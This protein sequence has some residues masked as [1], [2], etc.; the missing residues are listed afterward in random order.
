MAA[1][2]IR[3]LPD[4]VHDALRRLAAER[5]QPLEALVREKLSEFAR[6]PRGGIDFE[7]LARRRA[8]LGLFEDGPEWTP[9]MDD[10]ALSWKVLGMRAPKTT[11]K[12]KKTK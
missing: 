12:K 4:D 3:N 6:R 10:P 7:K 8:E 11:K 1:I 5:H 2:V 9:A